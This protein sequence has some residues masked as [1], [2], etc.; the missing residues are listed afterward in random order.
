MDENDASIF[1]VPHGM[2]TIS[3][4]EMESDSIHSVL[5]V[6]VLFDGTTTIGYTTSEQK[7]IEKVMNLA[8]EL[9]S[10]LREP[11]KTETFVQ[12]VRNERIVMKR[13]LGRLINGDYIPIKTYSYQAVT[14]LE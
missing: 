4:S 9:E 12:T 11:N 3:L 13:S 5:L 1:I 14:H 7:A 8:L 2:G 10:S 6:W